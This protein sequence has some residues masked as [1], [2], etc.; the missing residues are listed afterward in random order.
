MVC[1]RDE[2]LELLL[3]SAA[4]AALIRWASFCT[5]SCS[6]FNCWTTADMVIIG[7]PG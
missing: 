5:R 1:G 3:P 2:P 6:F 4:S 7:T